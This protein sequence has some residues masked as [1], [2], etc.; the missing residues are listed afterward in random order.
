MDI[1][2]VSTFSIDTMIQKIEIRNR[3]AVKYR[4]CWLVILAD[5][6]DVAWV[7][8]TMHNSQF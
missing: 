6:I 3:P 7:L 2:L 5:F 1:F 4:N 8:N